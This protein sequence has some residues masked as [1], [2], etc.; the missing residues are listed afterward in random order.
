[1][2]LVP[3]TAAPPARNRRLE[4]CGD[5]PLVLPPNTGA[6]DIVQRHVLSS[7]VEEVFLD[8]MPARQSQTRDRAFPLCWVPRGR[9]GQSRRAGDVL[10]LRGSRAQGHFAFVFSETRSALCLARA[11]PVVIR[12]NGCRRDVEVSAQDR[13]RL[14]CVAF[15][16]VFDEGVEPRELAFDR[17][18]DFRV[19]FPASVVTEVRKMFDPVT[20]EG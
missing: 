17:D 10:G 15:T 1:M 12:I 5:I 9:L 6:I 20:A 3:I 16:E 14:G 2:V 13:R 7:I 4:S 8:S 19:G 11:F 18:G